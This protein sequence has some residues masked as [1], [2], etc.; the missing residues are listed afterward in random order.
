MKILVVVNPIA[1]KGKPLKLLPKIKDMAGSNGNHIRWIVTAS[2][3][4]MDHLIRSAPSQ[5][6]D[7][8]FL[9]GGDGTVHQAL[10]ALQDIQLPFG[11][12]PLGRGNDFARNIG[13]PLAIQKNPLVTG[14]LKYMTIDSPL[15]NGIPFVSIASVGFDAL[16]T[17]LAGENKGFFQGTPGY[18]VC[19]LRALGRFKPVE[20]KITV[21]E[22]TW[23]GRIM[24]VA[25]ANGPY[26]GGGMKVAPQASVTSGLFSVCIVRQLSKMSLLREFPKVF[27]G[28]HTTHP[29]VM[30]KS[31]KRVTI[32]GDTA[33]DVC[34]DGETVSKLPAHCE[35]AARKL[36]VIL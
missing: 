18:V 2:A 31:G 20:V 23:K 30:I 9:T 6:Y 33:Y 11:L 17:Q 14:K 22:D 1:G 21:D 25:V 10:P 27:L 26:Y 7:S 13:L 24:L 3:A 36:S 28:K 35:I 4:E 12:I 15:V 29:K 19:V 8:V 5:G 16:V 34:A 32:Q